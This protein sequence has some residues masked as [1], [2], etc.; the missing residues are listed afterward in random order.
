MYSSEG[1]PY[2]QEDL[3]AYKQAKMQLELGDWLRSREIA[4]FF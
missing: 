3:N 4:S 2:A 1:R